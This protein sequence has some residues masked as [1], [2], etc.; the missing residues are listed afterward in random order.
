VLFDPNNNLLRKLTF[1]KSLA[2]LAYQLRHAA[3]VGDREWALAQVAGSKG[4]AAAVRDVVL[5][6]PFYGVRADAT[7]VAVGFDDGGAIDGALHDSDKRVILAAEAGAAQ[8]RHPPAAVVADLSRLAANSDPN[9]AAA[10]LQT[11]G[12]LHA[13]HI[14]ERLVR[15]LSLPSFYDAIAVGALQGLAAYGDARA[16]PLIRARTAYGTEDVERDTAIGALAQLAASLRRPQA[17]LPELLQIVAHDPLVSSRVAAANALG[18]L[19][20]PAAIPTLEAV[21]HNDSQTIVQITA[22]GDILT[23]RDAVAKRR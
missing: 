20:D 10:A 6:D 15:S 2:E 21:E 18:A 11:L 22:W 13:P 19:G 1:A 23:I 14:Y 3:H 12:G 4:A 7:T 8:L 5:H 9:V 17:A 16:L